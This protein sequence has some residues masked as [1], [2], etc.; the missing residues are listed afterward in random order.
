MKGQRI[1]PAPKAEHYVSGVSSVDVQF[2]RRVQEPLR[3][4]VFRLRVNF[5]IA[6]DIPGE[7][8]RNIQYR[9]RRNTQR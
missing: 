4:E 7:T 2:P 9:S 1:S 8:I 6:H 3:H 5:R